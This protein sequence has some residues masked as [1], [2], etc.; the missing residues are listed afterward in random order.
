MATAHDAEII[1]K[2]YELRTESVL[3]EARKFMGSFNPATFE[4]FIAVGREAGSD[5][6]AYW[7]QT[8]SYWDMACAMVLRGAIDADLF[9]D[10]NGEMIFYY[11]KFSQFHQQY[12]ETTGQPFMRHTA[13][14][15]EKY[16]AA[17]SRYAF[18]MKRFQP[19]T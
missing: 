15:I 9:L 4:E 18:M 16:P 5:R 1:L 10:C 17:Q 3:R 12:Q 6:N 7:R 11:A 2:L 19:A 8:L 14:L 13:A